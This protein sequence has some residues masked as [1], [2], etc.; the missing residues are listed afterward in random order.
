VH[1]AVRAIYLEPD[2][3]VGREMQLLSE[4]L[5]KMRE[6]TIEQEPN[7]RYGRNIKEIPMNSH[8]EHAK[9]AGEGGR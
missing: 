4:V 7:R 3:F 8:I 1:Y 6:D 9:N 5:R 2:D